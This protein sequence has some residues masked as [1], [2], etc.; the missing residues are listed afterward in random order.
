V[1]FEVC[2]AFLVS[3]QILCPPTSD[4]CFW[5]GEQSPVGLMSW[6]LRRPLCLA[7]SLPF[8]MEI[9]ALYPVHGWAIMQHSN[10]SSKHAVLWMKE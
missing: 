7:L 10:H 3:G 2:F 6:V 9:T 1:G 8:E 5:S 4:G